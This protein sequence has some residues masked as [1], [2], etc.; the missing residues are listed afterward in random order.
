MVYL[1]APTSWNGSI[2]IYYK[3]IR[4]F[5]MRHEKKIDSGIDKAVDAGRAAFDEGES[6]SFSFTGSHLFH[7]FHDKRPKVWVFVAAYSISFTIKGRK[8]VFVARGWTCLENLLICFNDLRKLSLSCVLSCDVNAFAMLTCAVVFLCLWCYATSFAVVY[9][10]LSLR[11]KFDNFQLKSVRLDLCFSQKHCQWSRIWCFEE[12]RWHFGW[13]LTV[14]CVSVC[15]PCCWN[16][17]SCV[18]DWALLDL[19]YQCHCFLLPSIEYVDWSSAQ[20]KSWIIED[21]SKF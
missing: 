16:C 2:T 7:Q 4:P 10:M 12:A 19:W 14:I 21:G 8:C 11:S 13:W 17:V 5:V 18:T 3:F 15:I 6:W 1:M 9:F 20:L